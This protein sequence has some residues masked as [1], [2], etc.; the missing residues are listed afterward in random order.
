MQD[1]NGKPTPADPKALGKD[2]DGKPFKEQWGY[3]SVVGM[4]L[5]LSGIAFAVNQA[6]R[7]ILDAKNSHVIAVKRIVKYLIETK[8]RGLVFKPSLDWKVD[9]YVYADFC[10]LW[11]SE[12]PNDP[13][14]AKF[15]TGY[16]IFL[17]GCV[18]L[19]KSSLQT[20][21]S[22][23]T[24]MAEY[25]ALSTV[26]RDMLPLKRLVKSI[27]KVVTGDDNVKDTT[28]SNIFEDSNGGLAVAT[29]LRIT[30]Q[31]KFFA[32]KLHFFREHVKTERNLQGEINIH[33]VDTVNKLGDLPKDW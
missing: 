26:M 22:V 15:R 16:V 3:A 7:F 31:G 12:D 13:I 5:H 9:C 6:A 1:A 28:K 30:F 25:V 2:V 11:G 29:L 18:L 20:E 14:V 24:M 33:K 4:L 32:V 17:A 21:T 19:W 23:S 27:A 10:G 8:D